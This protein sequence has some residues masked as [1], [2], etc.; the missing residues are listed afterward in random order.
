MAR[1][2]ANLQNIDKSDIAYLEGRVKDNSGNGGGTPVSEYV[3]GDLHQT[4]AKL[5]SLAG[6][7]YNSLPDNETNGYQLVE[8]L[9]ALASKND[10]V[11]SL[12]ASGNVLNI[13]VKIGK[14]KVNESFVC[15][16]ALDKP[17]NATTVKGT[18]D[19]ATK[20]AVFTG[21][22][23]AGEYVRVINN[24]DDVSF[25]RLVDTVNFEAIGQALFFLQKANQA[26]EDAGTL[27]V[28]ATTP[29]IN[30]NVFAKRVIGTLSAP[31]LATLTNN[32]LLSKEDKAIINGIGNARLRNVGSFSG[33]E[34]DGL[35]QGTNLVVDGDIQSA[36]ITQNTSAGNVI[37]VTFKNAMDNTSFK[38]NLS[39]QSQGNIE[40]DNDI[41]PVVWKAISPTQADVYVE[42]SKGNVQNLRIHL[43]IIQL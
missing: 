2:K 42:E 8:A 25:L 28:F 22:F 10:F 12:T 39:V 32:G 14:L 7:D 18:L 37:R 11:L 29:K 41:H 24:A 17:G 35:P 38:I 4:L 1:S 19:N 16:A 23:K 40:L 13:P 20:A 3:Y 21:D 36:V 34:V 6:I 30:K 15:K 5:M 26:Q 9:T 43:D 31:Y 33:L 27:D